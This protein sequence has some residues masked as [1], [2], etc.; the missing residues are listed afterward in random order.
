MPRTSHVM[1]AIAF[2][3]LAVAAAGA[4]TFDYG[5]IWAHLA[6]VEVPN[7]Y[8]CG[9][10][11]DV[12]LKDTVAYT[13]DDHD[14][15]QVVDCSDVSSIVYRGYVPVSDPR[16]CDV[17]D[18]FVYVV[19]QAPL[20]S[21]V[22]VDDHD[23]PVVVAQLPLG[24]AAREVLVIGPWLWLAMSDDT[25]RVYSLASPT[26]PAFVGTVSLPTQ[27]NE[28]L[29]LAGSRVVAAG[30][31]ALVVLSAAIPDRPTILGTHPLSLPGNTRDL[32]ARDDLA[33]VGQDAQ[34]RL[35]DIADP[36]AMVEVATLPDRGE[37]VLL[38]SNAQAWVAWQDCWEY[39]GLRIYDVSD[40]AAPSWL[41][42]EF[43]GFRGAP[44]AMVEHQ[45]QV[46]AA[47]WRCW[48]AGEWPGFH[49]LQVGSLPPPAP[50]AA[51]QCSGG[52]GIL[53]R[54]SRIDVATLIAIETWDLGDPADPQ[55][56]AT[57]GEGTHGF[58]LLAEDG[59]VVVADRWKPEWEEH[60]FQVLTRAAD[61]SLALRGSFLATAR[62][63]DLAVSGPL[64]LAALNAPNGT[65]A[66]DV[67]DPDAPVVLAT[68]LVGEDVGSL[69]LRERLAV[70]ATGTEL[71]VLDLQDLANPVVLA[72]VP[73][74]AHWGR[75]HLDLVERD[76]RRW[77]LAS[78]NESFNYSGG[79]AEIFDLAD[80]AA[81]RLVRAWRQLATD[82]IGPIVWR[83]D[84][85]VVP[86]TN[87]LTFY[88]CVDPETDAGFLGRVPVDAG[89]PTFVG[90]WVG[91]VA[92]AVATVDGAGLL[93]TWPLPVGTLTAVSP[94]EPATVRAPA[95]LAATVAP[96][97]FNPACELR[98]AV[99]A[100]GELAVAVYDARGRRVRALPPRVVA[101]GSHGV[102]W[103]GRDDDGR[104]AP[105]G[106]YL[107][108][109]TVGAST[110]S[111]KL[112]LAK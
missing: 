93:Q 95:A 68:L 12:A 62:I 27:G 101:P 9:G 70:V 44:F 82:D 105:A 48:C 47:E 69:A 76:G 72:T 64:A 107:A 41:H 106:I 87:H 25:L 85:L 34:C 86:G 51:R 45:G 58:R 30:D 80:P 6:D 28:R 98:I 37:G 108:R 38:T 36:A 71:R 50:L 100:A 60:W 54:G 112:T 59:D 92:T 17:R 13:I 52:G 20:L 94:E 19:S 57:V 53:A 11:V 91:P 73:H 7:T 63:R 88:R 78:R 97:P 102:R 89:W 39:G 18:H 81:P 90:R 31:A 43:F 109:I 111:V 26:A 21:V 32:A 83:D 65:L 49:T 40:P 110:T 4:V 1:T 79:F 22:D 66:I 10:L 8:D 35:V 29:V 84:L 56:V 67:T 75:Q 42:D 24:V 74:G 2:F 104:P 3:W 15:L 61:G 99:P 46:F 14:G 103:D 33:L 77:L 16:R 96:N 5:S 23:H 55:F